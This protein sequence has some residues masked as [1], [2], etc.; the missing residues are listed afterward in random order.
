MTESSIVEIYID[1]EGNLY[2]Y[3]PSTMEYYELLPHKEVDVDL[4]KEHK[5]VAQI[6]LEGIWR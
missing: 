4:M 2:L 6:N 3:T 1:K 5:M